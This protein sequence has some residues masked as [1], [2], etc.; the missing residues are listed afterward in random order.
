VAYTEQDCIDALQYVAEKLDESPST[1]DYVEHSQN[2]QPSC[3]T[4]SNHFGTWNS[5][6]QAAGLKTSTR[7]NFNHK[8]KKEFVKRIKETVGC[9]NCGK[10]EPTERMHFH[11]TDPST[12]VDDINTIT[13]N[14]YSLEQLKDEIKK[15]NILCIE[16]HYSH[17]KEYTKQDC[18]DALNDVANEL[19]KSPMRR[20]YREH[21]KDHQPC[22]WTIKEKLG[23]WNSAKQAAGLSVFA[24]TGNHQ[25]ISPSDTE[26]QTS[27]D[28]FAE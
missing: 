3:N 5:A 26:V 16:C 1:R 19:D 22:A 25:E 7:N 28:Q 23:S 13:K 4:I 11:H 27:F 24:Q 6:K 8:Q 20:E 12:K 15:C 17:H 10:E 14:S 21:S 9:S 2:H 18:I